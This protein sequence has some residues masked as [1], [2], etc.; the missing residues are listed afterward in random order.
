MLHWI[1][2]LLLSGNTTT[3][4]RLGTHM[5]R[6]AS[7]LGY[8]PSTLSLVRVFRSVPPHMFD[9]AANTVMYREANAR[10][11]EIVKA[12]TDPD[13]LT[14]QGIIHAKSVEKGSRLKALAAFSQA[15][16]A[17][18]TRQRENGSVTKEIAAVVPGKGT[19][20]SAATSDCVTNSDAVDAA[21]DRRFTLPPPRQPRWEWE[22]SCIL[23][24][25]NILVQ[26]RE[27][28]EEALKLFKVAAL[29]L[30]NP[31]GFLMLAKLMDGPRDSPERRVYLLK[32]AVSG[33]TE[34][35][36]EL[37]ELEALAAARNDLSQKQRTEHKMLSKEWLRLADG[38]DLSAFIKANV[39]D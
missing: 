6:S 36:Q 25:A 34:A 23:G 29:E 5:L 19:Q 20:A 32:A 17:W 28:T 1:G 22:V 11:Q 14:L 37:G 10:F 12:G 13:A 3:G 18:Q 9:R 16:T 39:G 24:Q 31:V 15:T 8:T 2:I 7:E 33:D 21:A 27:T 26:S 4:W 38:E 30:D 35:C